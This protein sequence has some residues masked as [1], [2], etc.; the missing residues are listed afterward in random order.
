MTDITPAE[1]LA[2]AADLIDA[3]GWCPAPSWRKK[4]DDGMNIIEAV[5]LAAVGCGVP[6]DA[7][8]DLVRLRIN[9]ARRLSVADFELDPR[10]RPSEVIA[11]LFPA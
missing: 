2:I 10:R 7:C 8:Y 3:N 11:L 6:V 9:P 5:K 4:P 1:A